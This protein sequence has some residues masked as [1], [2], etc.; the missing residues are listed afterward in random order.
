MDKKEISPAAKAVINAICEASK[1]IE[2]EEV[3]RQSEYRQRKLKNFHITEDFIK[4]PSNYKVPEWLEKHF[5]D[6]DL[7][8]KEGLLFAV[9]TKEPYEHKFLGTDSM[10]VEMESGEFFELSAEL[11]DWFFERIDAE[12]PVGVSNAAETENVNC[13]YEY[14]AK[15]RY[16]NVYELK[17]TAYKWLN[18]DMEKASPWLKD[19]FGDGGPKWLT[20]AFHD[21]RLCIDELGF[22]NVT[23]KGHGNADPSNLCIIMRDDGTFRISYM[24][25]FEH[26]YKKVVVS[27]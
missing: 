4:N 10:I 19:A 1:K 17:N 3:G 26:L 8:I 5:D 2:S 14:V 7:V 27:E 11:V 25:E 21:D 24:R 23:S 18:M 22:P 15:E 13:E 6:G 9:V 20:D 12:P 16:A